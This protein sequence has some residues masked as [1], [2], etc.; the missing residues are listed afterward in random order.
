[1]DNDKL[2]SIIKV[3]PFAFIFFTHQTRASTPED[4]VTQEYLN[5]TGLWV[6][7]AAE[8][9]SKGYTGKDITLGVL[10]TGVNWKHPEFKGKK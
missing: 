8:A 6:I 3:I 10:D 9:Y 5:S 7:N 4:F 1:M 2:F